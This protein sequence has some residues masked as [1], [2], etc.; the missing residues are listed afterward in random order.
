[1]SFFISYRFLLMML[2]LLLGFSA[3]ADEG[4]ALAKKVYD[5][6]DGR[7]MTT[8]SRMVLTEKGRAPRIRELVTYRMDTG[9][10]EI[11]NLIRFLD[12]E[13]IAGTGLLSIDKVGGDADQWLYLPALD[14][15]RRIASSRKG[16]RF[17]G[18]DLYF[19]DLQTRSPAKDRHRLLGQQTEAGILCDVLESMPV[20]PDNSVYRKRVSWIDPQTLLAQ[21]VDYFEKDESTPSKR[22]L[23][24]GKKRI[25][26]YWTVTDSRMI[27]LASGHETRMVIDHALYDQKLPARLFTTQALADETI[28]SEYR[29]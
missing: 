6:P 3:L 11:S 22:W 27:D 23:L 15:V 14:R 18:S 29:P 19:E 28:E 2:G 5:R 13:D 9:R 1:M 20:D 24:R 7:D 26:G 8:L 4:L 21:R 16:G 25:Q 12:P 17:V 10:D